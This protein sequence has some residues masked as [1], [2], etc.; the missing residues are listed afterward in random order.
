M[1]HR[2]RFHNDFIHP[3]HNPIRPPL[4]EYVI[5]IDVTFCTGQCTLHAEGLSGIDQDGKGQRK[6][7]MERLSYMIAF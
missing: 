4:F 3:S 7:G 1:V 5:C 2:R 6:T